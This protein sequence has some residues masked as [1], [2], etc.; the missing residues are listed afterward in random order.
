M[1]N[2]LEATYGVEARGELIGERLIV[3]KSVRLRRADGLFV[4]ALG[5]ELAALNACDLC[6]HQCGAVFKILRADLR[7]YLE[8]FVVGGQ[9]LEMLPSLVR[10]CGIPGCRVG[11]R[12]VVM[13][14]CRFEL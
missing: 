3:H 1:G 4:Q 6:A 14:L 8:L 9:S 7:P 5:I 13:K 12:T 10:E 2:G 11:K